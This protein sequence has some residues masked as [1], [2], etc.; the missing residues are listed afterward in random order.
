MGV[1]ILAPMQERSAAFWTHWSLSLC[2]AAITA[3]T[4]AQY[5][6]WGRR[7]ALYRRSLASLLA[8]Q[9]WFPRLRRKLSLDE[10]RAL[11]VFTCLFRVRPLSRVIP[12]NFTFDASWMVIP[13]S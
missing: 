9:P 1:V 3:K 7:T 12:K 4:G 5:S 11:I 8:P 13:P 6:R 10:Q 2:V